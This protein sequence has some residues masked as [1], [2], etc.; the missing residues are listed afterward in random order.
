MTRLKTAL[1]ALAAVAVMGAAVPAKAENYGVVDMNRVMRESEAAKGIFAE[2]D[3]KRKEFQE[4]I[5]KEKSG[6]QAMEQDIM[7]KKSSMSAEEFDK[8]RKEFQDKALAAEKRMQE[9]KRGLDQA[10]SETMKKFR[11]EVLK[12]TADIAKNKSYT[13]IFNQEAMILADPKM[14]I[15]SSVIEGVNKDVKKIAVAWPK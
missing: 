15:T 10:F 7:K 5:A 11:T 13:A 9:R 4:Q 1:M 8:K 3:T 2:L 12:V 6:L 14:D